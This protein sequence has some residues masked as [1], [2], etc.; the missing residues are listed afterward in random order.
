MTL[1][2]RALWAHDLKVRLCRE[3]Y[4][5]FVRLNGG[6]ARSVEMGRGPWN[7]D[8]CADPFLFRHG[9]ANWLFYETLDK[10]GKGVLGC[11]KEENGKWVQ[12]GIVLYEPKHLSYPK[13]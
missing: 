5:T 6:D 10:S 1:R 13:V 11:F 4:R 9:G 12:Q 3:R 7:A 8:Y 2:M